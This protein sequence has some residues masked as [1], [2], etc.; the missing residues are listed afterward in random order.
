M[1]RVTVP[2]VEPIDPAF[3]AYVSAQAEASAEAQGWSPA[4]RE[5]VLRSLYLL[6]AVHG[7]HENIKASAVATLP[8]QRAARAITRVTEVLAHLALLDAWIQRRL[9]NVHPEIRAEALVWIHIVRHGGPRRRP[10]ST[11]TVR[12]QVM[13]SIPF[14]LDCSKRYR[15]L[16]QVTRA[17]LA[18][19]LSQCAAPHNEA[20]ALRNMFKTLRSQRLLFANPARGLSLGA[21]PASVPT[22]LSLEAIQTLTAA[23]EDDPALKLLIALIGI[24]ALYPHQVRELP[25]AAIDFTGGRL[26]HGDID[27]P[28]DAFTVRPPPTTSNSGTHAGHTPATP[29]C[30]SARRPRTRARQS[31]SAGCSPC[32]T[33]PG[34]AAAAGR[35]LPGMGGPA[36]GPRQMTDHQDGGRPWKQAAGPC[37]SWP[38]W[39]RRRASGL[40]GGPRK[41]AQCR[42]GSVA[43][44]HAV[45]LCP[46]RRAP[47]PG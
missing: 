19:W 8:R 4:L 32:S 37:G 46:G 42:G 26:I 39:W 24:H 10:R 5:R 1:S 13:A 2:D 44:V 18:E 40:V 25:L 38:T 3:T 43:H 16:R 12:N 36:A 47:R 6:A 20:V 28:L 34:P 27:H 21:R 35:R 23:A 33:V 22:P 9:S 7:P 29:T 30:S 31:P 17:G 45:G 14:L 11:A 41:T 15:T